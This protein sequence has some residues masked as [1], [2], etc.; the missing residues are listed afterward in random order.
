MTSVYGVTYVGAREQIKKRLEER[1][2][3]ADEK[4]LFRVSCYAAK[5]ILTALE[6]MFQAARGIMN[7]L[8]QCAKVIASENQ[9]VRWTSPL[10]LPVV[11]PYMK[12]E[13]HLGSSFEIPLCDVQVDK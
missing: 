1:G 13:R 4:L 12:S 3:I 6:E 9:P 7:W 10:G 5:V 2:L 8:T 11:Q